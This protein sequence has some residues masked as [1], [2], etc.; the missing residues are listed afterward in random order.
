VR[1]CLSWPATPPTPQPPGRKLPPVPTLLLAGTHDLS[2][3][4]EWARHEAALAPR[5]K[6]VVVP[7]AGHSIQVRAV[8][9]K[10]R[11]AVARFLMAPK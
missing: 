9:D 10:G 4:L 3:P 1:Q 2:T 7:G 8:S 11:D 6:L 5:G